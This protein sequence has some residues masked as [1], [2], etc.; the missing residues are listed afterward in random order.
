[1]AELKLSFAEQFP[2]PIHTRVHFFLNVLDVDK[3]FLVHQC[4]CCPSL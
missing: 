4:H 1:L 3:R 2:R